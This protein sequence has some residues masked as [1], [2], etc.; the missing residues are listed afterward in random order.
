MLQGILC[1]RNSAVSRAQI[2]F[3]AL[4]CGCSLGTRL[5]ARGVLAS[6]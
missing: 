4:E 3:S 6:A 1:R 5:V 2:A